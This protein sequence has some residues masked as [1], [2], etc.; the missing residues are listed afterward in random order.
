MEIRKLKPEEHIQYEGLCLSVFFDTARRDIRQQKQD[1]LAHASN[2]ND[3][4]IGAV[5]ANGRLQSALAVI[6]YTMRMNGKD[7][8]M[9]G[10]GGV[11]TLPEARGQGLV[12]K[13]MDL[14]FEEMQDAGQVFSF[15]YPFSYGYYRKFGYEMCLP[16]N[17]VTIPIEQFTGYPFPQNITPYEPGNS[18]TP[19]VEIYE[20]FTRNRNLAIKRDTKTWEHL[21]NRDPY[22]N[23]EFTYLVQD[24]YILYSV[25]R[26]GDG[27]R[28]D[29]KEL[30]WRTPTGL[31]DIFGFLGKL[32]AEFNAVLWNAP[33]DIN[34][35]ALFPEGY[36]LTWRVNAVGMN[37][38]VDVTAALATLRA[39]H[40][41]GEVIIDVADAY[42]PA[43]SG[44][45]AVQWESGNLTAAKTTSGTADITTSIQ[46]LAQ[47]VTGYITP[48]EAGYK[49][50]TTIYNNI[51]QLFTKQNLF[52]T[53]R[54]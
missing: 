3:V 24:A 33:C 26:S 16:Y 15:L 49:Q 13:I 5:D 48:Q 43:N 6:P 14:A 44:L 53:E 52:L 8:K 42:R 19:F 22:Q 10:I 47:L 25:D 40:G 12:R 46:T 2:G 18:I 51:S 1:P 50:D 31:R 34:I 28:V 36:D 39:P 45:Y 27:S 21:L 29:I 7:V 54:F 23:L 38:I 9:G 4:R 32:G 30:C 20:A 11:V 37:R 35:H 41:N 17:K